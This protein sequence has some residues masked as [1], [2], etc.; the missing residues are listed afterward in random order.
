MEKIEELIIPY[1]VCNVLISKEDIYELFIKFDIIVNIKSI[2]RYIEALTHKSYI[3]SEYT[4]YHSID[5]KKIK[6]NIKNNIIE[7]RDKSSE[8]LE[9]YGD[10]VIKNII[11][12]YLF[13]RY[14]NEDEGFLTRI[15]TKIENKKSLAQFARILGIQKYLIISQQIEL[16]NGRDSN[17]LLEDAFEAFLGALEL[18]VGYDICEKFL[19]KL[20]ESEIDYADLLYKDT[21]FKDKLLRFFHQNSWSNPIYQDKDNYSINNKKYFIVDVKNNIGDIIGTGIQLSKKKA[22]QQAAMLALVKY[23]QLYPDQI[24]NE[25]DT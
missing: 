10:T 8:R 14:K 9:H 21:N 2:D 19:F 23:N 5:I 1:N 18:D 7:L 12:K 16:N 25:F 4:M 6:S 17:K 22:E 24:V 11:A 13:L 3:K 20:L 15:K